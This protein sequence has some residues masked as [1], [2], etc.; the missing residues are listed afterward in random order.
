MLYAFTNLGNCY[1]I[2]PEA[3]PEASGAMSGGIKFNQLI[4]NCDKNEVPVAFYAAKDDDF[5]TTRLYFFTKGGMVKL[6]PWSEYDV[7]KPVFQAIKLKE[8]DELLTMEEEIPDSDFFFATK[9]GYC[10]N[11]SDEFP[12]QLRVASGV[13]GMD[14]EDGDEIITAMQISK[15][16]D[17]EVVVSTSFGT[18]K[19]VDL[20]TIAKTARARKGVRLVDIGFDGTESVKLAV[21]KEESESITLLIEDED[22]NVMHALSEDLPSESRTTKGKPISKLGMFR[23]KFACFFR[24]GDKK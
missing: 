7:K 5:P 23:T 18:F 22:G 20:G 10:L 9:N 16:Y 11:C 24:V 12:Q 19:K 15:K 14:L 21:P 8:D 1:K 4:K 2:D 13:K 17:Y 6:T 3:L